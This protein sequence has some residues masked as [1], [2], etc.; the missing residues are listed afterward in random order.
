MLLVSQRGDAP[1]MEPLQGS[2]KRKLVDG[3]SSAVNGISDGMI[4]GNSKRLCLEDVT[5]AMGQGSN[6]S[7]SRPDLQNSPFAPSAPVA[8][9]LGQMNGNGMGSPFS[10]EIKQSPGGRHNRMLPYDSN[11]PQS[12]EQELQELLDE[13]TKNPDPSLNELDPSLNEILDEPV[14]VGFMHPDANSTPKHSP[15]NTAH[16]ENHLTSKEFSPGF[17]QASVGSPQVGPPSAGTPYTLPHSSKPVPS[18]LSGSGQNQSQS[19]ARSPM[20]SAALSSWHEVSH[21]QQLK[22]M[23][24]SKHGS[25]NQQQQQQQQAA[26]VSNWPPMQSSGPSPPYRTEKLPSSSPHQQPFSPQNNL[27]SNIQSPQ[28]SLISNM[29]SSNPP[30]TGPSPPYRPE[31]L[32]SPALGQPPFS[33]QNPMLPNMAAT[34][35]PS[36]SIQSPQASMLP[37]LSSSSTRPS[38]PYRPDKLSSP[39]IQ[40][41][42]FSPQ[43]PM[44]TNA[45]NPASNM[46][47]YKAMTSTQSNNLNMMMSQ[48][49]SAQQQQQQAP[50]TSALQPGMM[51]K[52]TMNQDHYSFNN[53][54]PL[55]HFDP[56][57]PG[58]M[59]PMPGGPGQPPLAHYLQQQPQPPPQAS[60]SQLLQQQLQ[61]RM[62]RNN[63]QPGGL[64]PPHSRQEQSPGMVPRLQDPSSI[65]SAGI[66]AGMGN[67]YMKHAALKQQLI[68]KQQQHLLQEKQRQLDQLNGNRMEYKE[69][70]FRG[71]Q[72]T[73]FPGVA[74]PLPQD[75]GHPMP[76]PSANPA[77]IPPNPAMLPN[78]LGIPPGAMPQSSRTMGVFPSNAG[79]QPGL[80]HPAHSDF[81]MPHRS[82]GML[83]M[84]ISTQP[85]VRSGMPSSSFNQLANTPALQQHLRHS[86]SQQASGMPRIPNVSGIR[87]QM[88]AAQQGVPRMPGTGQMD[89]SLQQF[90]GSPMFSKAPMRP[91]LPSQFVQTGAPP[92]QMAPG[93]I[94]HM[95]KLNPAQGNP[96]ANQPI[97]NRGPLSAMAGM[98]PIPPSMASLSQVHH[99]PQGLAPPSYPSSGKPT[100]AYSGV[101]PKLPPY[102][103]V[104]QQNSGPL[105]TTGG[106]VDFI[107][108]FMGEEWMHHLNVIDEYL[109]QHS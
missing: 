106:E 104:Q 109:G 70:G 30:S 54:K 67:G 19:Q 99:P 27:A 23:A 63:M 75:C 74:R 24:A 58:K 26:Q 9:H 82:Q 5:L 49:Q 42:T 56:D 45:S 46:Q 43:N 4:P 66:R 90:P 62:Q 8:S 108:S 10:S 17:S 7:M 55:S 73:Q 35:L 16:L 93:L 76:N 11:G 6:N 97:R 96:L 3:S 41:H 33:P 79:S 88:W 13:L 25:T 107:D 40:Q 83:G 2:I 50:H 37:N 47:L 12:V 44:V 101:S 14:S 22:Q 92:N 65:P 86:L 81:N 64:L 98:K 77:M 52:N 51:N 100:A 29:T 102:E 21:A 84:G 1:R 105:Q 59:A 61:Q 80:Y 68:R 85:A 39:T 60:H 34:S 53:T 28:N 87:P 72:L 36:N 69:Q 78:R 71:Q 31:K 94:R 103:F 91:G 18:V 57:S 15:Q 89:P 48:P 38:P 20:L 95:Q 32:A